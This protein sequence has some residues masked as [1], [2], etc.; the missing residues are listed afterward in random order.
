M[1]MASI[2]ELIEDIKNGKFVILVDD[3]DRENEGDLFI[4]A[5]KISP[6]AIN[7]MAKNARG[8][9]CVSLTGE[10]LD[11][12]NIPLMVQENSSKHCTA[13]TVSVEARHR[14]STGISAADRAETVK[15]LIDPRTRPE[16][17]LKPGH[18]FPLRARDGGVLVRAGHTEASV[19]LS[20]MAGLYPAGVICEIMDED[21]T[22]ARLPKLEK[23]AEEWGL[24][25]GSVANLIA[26]RRR[27]E[28]LVDRVA[29][30]RLPT[31]YGEFTAIGYK[32]S[33]D[34]GEHL[35]LV[36]GAPVDLVTD[37]PVLTRVHSECLT[38]DVLGSLRCD[39]GEQLDFAL[40]QIAAAGTGVL[41][42][43]RQEGRGIG[44]HN[45]IC[46]YALQDQGLDT[47]EANERLGFDA[48]LRDYGIGAQ[49]LADL[50][51]K[52]IKLLTNNPKK[53]VGL[54]GY[55][56]KVVETV[57]IQ[58]EPNP[59]NVKYLETKRQKMGHM[60]SPNG[61]HAEGAKNG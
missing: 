38:G 13:F 60:L 6:E 7:F 40:K 25:I 9:I 51:L 35:A 1:T 22:M 55:G 42:Y 39:C 3:D 53:V 52:Q 44:F 2:S 29:E 16:D 37:Q 34:P 46:A 57:P 18:T 10:R 48:D 49:I 15:T 33:V 36:Y 41:L 24:K 54:E 17:L 45:K 61:K 59:H 31:R 8:L 21:G 4:A 23:L 14:V 28:K 27:T 11:A 30:A 50:G 12:L 58:I 56:L 26:Y 5:E 20:R 32:S 19:D 47:V 43:M